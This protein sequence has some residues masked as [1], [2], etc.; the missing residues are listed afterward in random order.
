MTSVVDV[1]ARAELEMENNCILVNDLI[2]RGSVNVVSEDQII[3]LRNNFGTLDRG[4]KCQFLHIGSTDECID[5]DLDSCPLDF[6]YETPTPTATPAS[7]ST[8]SAFR[9]TMSGTLVVVIATWLL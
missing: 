7:T 4:L 1:N 9:T 6:D 8:S 5:Y 2:G 3:S